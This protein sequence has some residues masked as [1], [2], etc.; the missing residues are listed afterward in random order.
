MRIVKYGLEL[1]N[2]MVGKLVKEEAK[3]CAGIDN[4]SFLNHPEKVVK[5]MNTAFQLDKKAEEYVYLVATNKKYKP[6]G[7]FEISH[8]TANASFAS[9]RCIYQRA[10]LCGATSIFL[11][12]NHPSG[13]VAPSTE[14]IKTTR[15]LK[16]A[17]DL[18]EVEFIDS[19]I[20]GGENYYSF[21]QEG[22]VL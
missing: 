6:I 2:D 4:D 15:K 21:R 5:I 8:G 13:D 7:F 3:N 17:G 1:D 9:S 18:L 14:D 11:V 16:E 10:L 22:N 20:I 19:I 12:H